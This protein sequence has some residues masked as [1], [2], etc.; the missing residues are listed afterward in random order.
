MFL[1]YRPHNHQKNQDMVVP[2]AAPQNIRIVSDF[3][4]LI[5]NLDQ[6]H[7]SKFVLPVFNIF[8]VFKSF[9]YCMLYRLSNPLTK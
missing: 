3:E 2:S 4:G 9:S 7:D 8:V 1:K 5:D 6:R